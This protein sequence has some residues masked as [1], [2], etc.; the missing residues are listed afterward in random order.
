[1]STVPVLTGTLILLFFFSCEI[2][3]KEL[4]PNEKTAEYVR[5]NIDSLSLWLNKEFIT[6]IGSGD[7]SQVINSFYKGR[8]IYKRI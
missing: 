6:A 7:S 2:K 5:K 1:L 8:K 4:T 3:Q